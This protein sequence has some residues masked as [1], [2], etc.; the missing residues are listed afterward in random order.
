MTNED[1]NFVAEALLAMCE[2]ESRRPYYSEHNMLAKL[3]VAERRE[4]LYGHLVVQRGEDPLLKSECADVFARAKL[5]QRQADVLMKRLEGWTFEEI[6]NAGGH[7]KQGAQNIFVQALK[8][9]AR[10]FRVYP[11]RGLSEVYRW[12]TRRGSPRAGVGKIAQTAY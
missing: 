3:K 8:K 6:G 2:K 11:F 9:I 4:P 1:L 7:S 12:E 10:S 5:T